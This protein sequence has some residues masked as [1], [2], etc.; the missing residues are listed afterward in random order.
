[1][2]L[3]CKCGVLHWSAL[4][5]KNDEK[6]QL[7]SNWFNQSRQLR[8][9]SVQKMSYLYSSLLLLKKRKRLGKDKHVDFPVYIQT[10]LWIIVNI[11]FM[12]T[13]YIATWCYILKPLE[14]GDGI[15]KLDFHNVVGNTIMRFLAWCCLY[16][17][18]PHS[19]QSNNPECSIW[20]YMFVP[21]VTS[22][23][24]SIRY[25]GNIHALSYIQYK[26]T[27]LFRVL[28]QSWHWWYWHL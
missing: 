21:L 23:H 22:V 4:P 16:M 28:I 13:I 11:S 26:K 10:N 6:F 9:L 20:N 14:I 27:D 18:Y 7:I 25:D 12:E 19:V 17:V 5:N 8:L 24:W 3:I 2:F 1:M 15:L